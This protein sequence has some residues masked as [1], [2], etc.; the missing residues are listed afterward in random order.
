LADE[1]FLKFMFIF[2]RLKTPPWQGC[3]PKA[4][5]PRAEKPI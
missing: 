1:D 2:K 3:P 5:Q 4:D